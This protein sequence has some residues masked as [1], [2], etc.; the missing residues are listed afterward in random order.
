MIKAGSVWIDP[1]DVVLMEWDHRHY[2]NSGS[3]SC[4]VIKTRDGTTFHV[5]H[6]ARFIGGIDAYAV[7]KQILEAKKMGGNDGNS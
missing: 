3:D 6:Q 2:M 4:L 7:E 5:P 1:S